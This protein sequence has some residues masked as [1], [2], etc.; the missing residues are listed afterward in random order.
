[1]K[2]KAIVPLVLGLCIGLVAVKYAVDAVK[3][4]QAAG[5]ETASVQVVRAVRDIGVGEELTADKLDV[6]ETAPNAFIPERERV[7]DIESIEGRVV[8]KAISQGS[9]VLLNMLAPEGTSAGMTGRIEPGFRAVSV[10]IDEVTGVAYQINPNDWVDVIVVMD[11][12]TGRGQSE[13]IAE[14]LLQHM[15]VVAVGR[16]IPGPPSEGS[17]RKKGKTAKSVTLM[18]PDEDVPKLH[19]AQTRGKLTLALRGDDEIIKPE[20]AF[21][22]LGELLQSTTE[23]GLKEEQIQTPA[24]DVPESV[25]VTVVDQVEPDPPHSIAI[26]RGS[27]GGNGVQ[28][29]L[30]TFENA[31]SRNVVDLSEGPTSGA[32]SL[33]GSKRNRGSSSNRGSTSR[34]DRLNDSDL[35]G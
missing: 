19:L 11:I 15:Q 28:I 16:S 6:V 24:L 9:A 31:W 20:G 23:F 17:D 26:Y 18:I 10:R 22:R 25:Q 34:Q 12:K 1:M 32:S 5:G 35:E 27:P 4:A 2:G 33:M 8:S 21:A 3:S 29:E 14:V 7:T 13:T 30:I